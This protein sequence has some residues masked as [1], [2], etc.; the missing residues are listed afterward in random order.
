MKYIII[1]LQ[2]F[3]NTLVLRVW[4][5][6]RLKAL[7]YYNRII[8]LLG[9]SFSKWYLIFVVVN[10]YIECDIYK[11][12]LNNIYFRDHPIARAYAKDKII[13]T[14]FFLKKGNLVWCF[15]LF[16]LPKERKTVKAI[17]KKTTVCVLLSITRVLCDVDM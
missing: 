17:W 6:S 15:Q 14:S 10:T 12:L 3:F 8:L 7:C 4:L 11:F 9:V 1:F 5:F 2:I 16:C 13:Y